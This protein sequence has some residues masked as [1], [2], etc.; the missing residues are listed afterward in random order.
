MLP[1]YKLR[2]G[3]LSALL[4]ACIL[5]NSGCNDN[6]PPSQGVSDSTPRTSTV[7][8]AD[9]S[10]PPDTDASEGSSEAAAAPTEEPEVSSQTERLPSE[11]PTESR[12][13]SSDATETAER[14]DL[15]TEDITTE[16]PPTELT[17]PPHTSGSSSVIT[18]PATT[19]AT[20]T[21]PPQTA[22]PPEPP[23][24]TVVPTIRSVSAPGA[25]TMKTDAA[26]LDYSNASCGYIAVAYTGGSARAK[27]RIIA[28]GVTNDHDLAVGGAAEYFPLSMGSGNYEI[29]VYEQVEGKF[30][31]PVLE[32]SGALNISDEVDMYLYPNKYVN[33]SQTSDCVYKSA[34]L[35]AGKSGTVER[36]A[37]IFAYVTENVTYDYDLAASVK[38]GYIPDPDGTLKR[39][40]GIC[41]DYAS[42][43]AAMARAQGI[44]T[45]LVIGYAAD[46]IYHAWNEVYTEE[47]GWISAELLLSQ[48]GYNIVDATFYAGAADKDAIA[49]YISNDGNYSAIYRY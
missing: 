21:T 14:S 46:D 26:V 7:S 44:P 33:F 12:E 27:L 2:A 30:Y 38:S 39:R 31:S 32:F 15:S 20:T 28:N 9:S 35:C 17:S 45:R 16:E 22:A 37:A 23:A 8:A 4:C 40:K 34:E 13:S 36:L 3:I 43:V 5:L 19:P 6:A 47:T 41:F 42:L 29:G 11:E 18:P 25:L 49:E 1:K 24:Q 10:E 48:K